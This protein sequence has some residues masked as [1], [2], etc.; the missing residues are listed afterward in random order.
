MSAV[1]A[2]TAP[3][4]ISDAPVRA[5]LKAPSATQL[6]V[7]L[8]AFAVFAAAAFAPQMLWDG[9]TLW[10]LKTGEWML[11]HHQIARADPFSF[12][13]PG[14]AWTNLEWLSEIVMAPVFAAGGWSGLQLLFALALGAAAW[15][16][17]DETARRLPAFSWAAGLFLAIACTTQS[18]LARPHLLVL[19]ILALWT[20]Q[21]MRAREARRAPPFWLIPVMTLWANLHGSFVLGLALIAPFALEALIED[22]KDRLRSVGA[23]V[24]FGLAA[25]AAAL[26]TPH[27]IDGILHP[28]RIGGMRTLQNIAEWK[29][30]D[31]SRT[32]PLELSLLA[33][34]FALLYRGVKVPLVRLVV[35]VGLLHLT[36]HETRHQMVLAIVALLLLAEPIG[37]ALEGDKPAFSLPKLSAGTRTAVLAVMVLAFAGVAAARMAV[38]AHLTDGQTAPINAFAHVPEE[39]KSQPMLNDYGMGGYLIFRG[40]KPFIDGRADMYGDDF[41]DAYVQAVKPDPAKLKALLAKYRIRWTILRAENPA[42]PAMDAMPG[43]KRL[44]ADKSAVVHVKTGA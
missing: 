7:L 13:V 41:F 37:K 15:I 43:W 35:L 9:D 27:G 42:V 28:L 14:K 39:L 12:T 34:L 5:G 1:T 36:L 3:D 21:L 8:G 2:R 17:G 6:M 20:V 30:T 18:W 40:S 31:F 4:D 26:V 10:H 33:G 29:S 11:A 16:M 32:T 25:G 23:W 44:Y 22:G 38:P 19:P 24:L